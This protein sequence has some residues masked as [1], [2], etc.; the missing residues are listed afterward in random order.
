MM[1]NG[2]IVIAS[3]RLHRA[4]G[5]HNTTQAV[6]AVWCYAHHQASPVS[7]TLPQRTCIH[8]NADGVTTMEN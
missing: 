8:T 4:T 7:P 1:G 5:A 3:E 6:G 2:N